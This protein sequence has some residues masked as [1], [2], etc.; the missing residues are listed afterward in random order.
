M[1]NHGK[2]ERYN[3]MNRTTC[4]H[5]NKTPYYMASSASGQGDLNRALWLAT[6][7]GK[8]EASCPLGTTRCIPQEKFPR[9]P[10]NK[11][12]IIYWLS[13]FGQDGWILASFFFCEFAINT[14]KRNLANI[15]PSWPHT[16][17]ITH[18]YVYSTF[19]MVNMVS[20][21]NRDRERPT[22]TSRSMASILQLIGTLR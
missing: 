22:S 8:M 13:L 18:I 12:F 3:Y 20:G 21:M 16:W 19:F 1:L 17:S 15:Q 4:T 7:A 9:K 11:S 2:A 10:Y 5:R 6:R 14:Q